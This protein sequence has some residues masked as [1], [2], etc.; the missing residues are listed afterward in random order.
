[1]CQPAASRRP[2]LEEYNG[3]CGERCE[4]RL[5]RKSATQSAGA[6]SLLTWRISTLHCCDVVAD[7]GSWGTRHT[8]R[9]T[10]ERLYDRKYPTYFSFRQ[11]TL[12]MYRALP[13]NHQSPEVDSQF[14]PDGKVSFRPRLVHYKRFACRRFGL[15]RN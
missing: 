3:D 4:F 9:L 5:L 6:D 14:F 2:G 11:S 7:G 15:S 10:E 12:E 1:M 8:P 13:K